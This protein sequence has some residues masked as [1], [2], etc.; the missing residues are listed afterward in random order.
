VPHGH[1]GQHQEQTE[2]QGVPDREVPE[3]AINGLF[4]ALLWAPSAGNLQSRKFYFVIDT[5]TKKKLAKAALGQDFISRAPLVV[6]ACTDRRI[7]TRYGD[8]G[9]NLYSIQDAAA[10]VMNMMLVAHELGL[11]TVWVGA[12]NEFDVFEILD[13]PENLRPVAIIP[14]GYPARTPPAPPRVRREDAIVFVK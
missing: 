12:F 8:R 11:G 14:V 2:H 4:D 5:G 13:L 10:S 7:S 1:S 6:V 3:Q 9:V